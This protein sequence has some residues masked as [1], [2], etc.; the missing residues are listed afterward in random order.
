MILQTIGVQS[1]V[2]IVHYPQTGI[3]VVRLILQ[4]LIAVELILPAP[5]WVELNQ[6]GPG[7]RSVLLN[8]LQLLLDAF[9]LIR[10]FLASLHD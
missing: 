8:F 10:H 4:G 9:N 2:G 7:A 5:I 3:L 1:A 6:R